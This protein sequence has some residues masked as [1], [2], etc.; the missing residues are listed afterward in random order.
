MTRKALPLFSLPVFS[1]ALLSV[2]CSSGGVE[3]VANENVSKVGQ[4][5]VNGTPSTAADDFVVRI[6]I[7]GGGLC[8]GTMIA[9]NLVLTARHCV[10]NMNENSECGTFTSNMNPTSF[11]IALGANAGTNSVARG[12]KLF[13]ETG[14]G[15]NSGCSHDIALI[16]LDKAVPGAKIAKVRLY[17]LAVGEAAR[18]VGYGESGNGN[19]TPGR[20]AKAGIK[21]DMVGP[22]NYSYK[23]KQSR[24]IPVDVPPG[25]IVTGESTCFG[26]SG[27]PLF[28]GANNVIG[29]T[30]R[31]V[32]DSCIDRPSIY[33]DTASHATLIKNAA[34]SAGYPLTEATPPT[35]PTEPED[36]TP[37]TTDP[38]DDS[39]S[40]SS[41][42][43]TKKPSKSSEEE[44]EEDSEESTDTAP[45]ASAG[46]SAAPGSHAAAPSALAL[47]AL[48]LVLAAR[49][50]KAL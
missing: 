37:A 8:T 29:V 48:G 28:D 19:L 41:S 34:T 36:S 42:G 30:S 3:G 44:S 46:C 14:S 16:Q 22:G 21:I 4:R 47:L 33:S 13:T 18:T 7:G 6:N 26:D 40:T 25:E 27:G 5:I 10:S 1:L 35:K 15:T 31:G 9:P 49:R 11:T 32:D 23:T 38:D 12:T 39:K 17:A 43:S 2:A 45:A 20:Y 24:T 50:R